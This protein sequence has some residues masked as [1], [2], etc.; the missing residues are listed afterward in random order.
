MQDAGAAVSELKYC[1]DI[2]LRGV[3]IGTNINGKY[4]GDAD[5]PSILEKAE[6]LGAFF[7]IHPVPGLGGPTNK[8][9]YLWN[10][11]S[12]PAETH[13]PHHT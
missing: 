8:E 12:N 3:E 4:L 10:A 6:E 9:F 5:F 2:G 11:F 13:L 1:M 7:Q